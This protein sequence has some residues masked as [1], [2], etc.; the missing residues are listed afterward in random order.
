MPHPP[1][2]PVTSLDTALANFHQLAVESFI[3]GLKLAYTQQPAADPN[4]TQ[5]AKNLA[6]WDAEKSKGKAQMASALQQLVQADVMLK[7]AKARS[8]YA[9]LVD[10]ISA[11]N[12]ALTTLMT[13]TGGA[14]AE[15]QARAQ[16]IAAHAAFLQSLASIAPLA[17]WQKAPSGSANG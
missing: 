4:P 1:N 17:L 3:E 8:S 11:T 7:E 13:T 15:Q 5:H 2:P 12:A 10:L 6:V 16:L 9:S 14:T